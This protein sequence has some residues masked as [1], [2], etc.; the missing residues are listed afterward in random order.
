MLMTYFTGENDRCR[1]MS[2]IKPHMVG[3]FPEALRWYGPA[4]GFDMVQYEHAHVTLVKQGYTTS[5]R[6]QSG[7]G[8]ALFQKV[9]ARVTE[10]LRTQKFWYCLPDQINNS[11]LIRNLINEINHKVT[12]H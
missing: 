1:G 12:E 6:R 11:T 9:R 2:V 7:R 8:E 5:S 10:L 4:K 3:H